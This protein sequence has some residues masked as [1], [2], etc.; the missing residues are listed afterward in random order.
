MGSLPKSVNC[1]YSFRAAFVSH[2]RVGGL[3]HRIQEESRG[4]FFII[5][6]EPN[7]QQCAYMFT[8]ILLLFIKHLYINWHTLSVCVCFSALNTSAPWKTHHGINIHR[9][10]SQ[11]LVRSVVWVIRDDTG[12]HLAN[13][14]IVVIKHAECRSNTGVYFTVTPVYTLPLIVCDRFL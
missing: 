9:M 14:F 8:A 5:H 3:R 7:Q 6:L 4:F 13:V 1:I 2:W 10:C 12:F 11:K